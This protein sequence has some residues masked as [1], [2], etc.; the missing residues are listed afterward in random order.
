MIGVGEKCLWR[1]R[2]AFTASKIKTLPG[3]DILKTSST[4]AYC[5]KKLRRNKG[6]VGKRSK[7]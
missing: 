4:E 3:S 5:N 6:Y 1:A 2:K 7:Q